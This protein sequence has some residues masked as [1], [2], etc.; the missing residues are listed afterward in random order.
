MTAV[1]HC[2]RGNISKLQDLR[3]KV[4]DVDSKKILK[5][6]KRININH[7]IINYS[8][9]LYHFH[10]II[11]YRT[12][13]LFG[14]RKNG[15][16]RQMKNSLLFIWHYRK[17]KNLKGGW[18]FASGKFSELVSVIILGACLIFHSSLWMEN[19]LY[20]SS[21]LGILQLLSLFLSIWRN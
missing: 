21:L 16:H 7:L 17:Y 15:M 20:Y 12:Y 5:W 13:T 11:F 19:F 3:I 2:N 8:E 10:Y 14:K 1:V 4:V 9:F 6:L 18:H